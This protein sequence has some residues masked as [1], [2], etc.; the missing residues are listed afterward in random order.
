MAR[1]V[2]DEIDTSISEYSGQRAEYDTLMTLANG[3]PD[4]LV[5]YHNVHWTHAEPSGSVYGE[6]DF[7]VGNRYGKLLAIE[8]KSASVYVDRSNELRVDYGDRR[9]KS[10]HVQLSRNLNSLRTEF[11]RRY[12]G[13]RL[14]VDYLLYMPNAVLSGPTPSGLDPD[15]VVDSVRAS[16]LCQ[17]IR[18]LFD[19]S[20][21]PGG[22]DLADPIEV[23]DFLSQKVYAV[24]HIGLLGKSAREFTTRASGG[25]STWVG[26]LHMSPHRLRV[27]GTAGSGKTQLALDELRRADRLGQSALYVCYN[28]ALADALKNTAPSSALVVTVHE[29]AR[30]LGLQKGI[31]FEFSRPGV[32]DE[33]INVLQEHSSKLKGIFDVLVIDE[34]QDLESDWVEAL[35]QLVHASGRITLLEDP[36]QVLYDRSR[37]GSSALLVIDSPVNFRSPRILVDFINCLM[38]TDKPIIAGSGVVGFN[39]GWHWYVDKATMFDETEAALKYLLAQGFSKES[40]VILTYRGV[41]SSAFFEMGAPKGLNSIALKRQQGYTPDGQPKFDEGQILVE[42][43]YRFKGQAA[44]AVILTEVDFEALDQRNRRKLFVALSRARLHAVLI[45]SERSRDALLK[46]FQSE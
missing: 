12:K 21:L 42:T 16:K 38:L 44:D 22:G 15:R 1:I 33:M 18:E 11:S 37:Y 29:F 17:I 34:C 41:E 13:K 14:S 31:R 30:E 9:G 45:T 19:F 10:V 28:R 43:L 7:I 32:Y 39:P 6:I 25:L 36:E 24:P 3:L 5:V 26:R 20:S 35:I 40:I 23:H 27:Q 2:P 8:Q 46:I 4:D